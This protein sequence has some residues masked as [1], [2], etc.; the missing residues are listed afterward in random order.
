MIVI[1]DTTPLHYLVLIGHLDI[2]RAL[3]GKVVIPEAVRHELQARRT[4][5]AVR[6]WVA[7]PPPWIEVRRA[8][9]GEIPSFRGLDPG[10]REAIALAEAMRADALIMD[11]RA[12]RREAERRGLRVIGTLR[13]LYDAA[14]AGLLN[15]AEA[16]EALYASG[17]YVDQRLSEELLRRHAEK[18]AKNG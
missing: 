18:R 8:T 4:P 15:L 17:F 10:E 1:A 16:L 7:N 6:R 9:V 5:E 3:Y 13:V 11:D 2:L 14:Q 12:A